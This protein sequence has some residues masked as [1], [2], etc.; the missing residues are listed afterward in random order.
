MTK[1]Q[2]NTKSEF[3]SERGLINYSRN[4]EIVKPPKPIDR[5]FPNIDNKKK[6]NK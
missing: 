3:S 4:S 5:I 1:S 2:R 6:R